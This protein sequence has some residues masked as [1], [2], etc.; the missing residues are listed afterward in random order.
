MTGK[1]EQTTRNITTP[2]DRTHWQ[3]PCQMSSASTLIF[4]PGRGG[5]RAA[6]IGAP[7]GWPVLIA[8]WV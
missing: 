6:W 1:S 2:T 8:T 7:V 5:D 4:H 3:S